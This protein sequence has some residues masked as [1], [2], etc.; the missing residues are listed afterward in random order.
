LEGH[1]PHLRL[2][3]GGEARSVRPLFRVREKREGER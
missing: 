3:D 1:F 2:T